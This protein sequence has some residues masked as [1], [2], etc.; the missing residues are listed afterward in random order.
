M[1][2]GGMPRNKI[3]QDSY[4][5]FMRFTEESFKIFICAVSRRN[6]IKVGNIV[7][8]IAERRFKAG[9]KPYGVTTELLYII[10]LFDYTRKVS[11]TV[12]I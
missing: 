1:F 7:A 10:K 8:R 6:R 11:H 3:K 12:G 5:F 4:A 2:G 9:I